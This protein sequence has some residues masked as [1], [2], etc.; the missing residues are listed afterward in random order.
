MDRHLIKVMGK[1]E[2]RH[3]LD[4]DDIRELSLQADEFGLCASFSRVA[5]PW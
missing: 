3:E 1:P 4:L 5:S 2:Q